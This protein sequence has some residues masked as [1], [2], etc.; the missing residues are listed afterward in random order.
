[1]KDEEDVP[2]LEYT[3]LN[4]HGTV[5][6]KVAV[7]QALTLLDIASALEISKKKPSIKVL[8]QLSEMWM[9]YSDALDD[10]AVG[11]KK[12]SFGFSKPDKPTKEDEDGENT[13]GTGDDS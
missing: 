9:D 5:D 8:K 3:P 1:M 12:G 10:E 11:N 7:E 6:K 4:I 2:L 13:S